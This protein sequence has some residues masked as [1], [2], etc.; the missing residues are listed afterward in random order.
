MTDFLETIL[1][2]RYSIFPF[3]SLKEWDIS[4][5]MRLIPNTHPHSWANHDFKKLSAVS[6]NRP[7]SYFRKGNPLVV[8]SRA[9]GRCGTS[10]SSPKDA[11]LS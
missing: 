2:R 3:H 5:G 7:S 1:L 4:A 6:S 8:C 9:T 11:R 10:Y